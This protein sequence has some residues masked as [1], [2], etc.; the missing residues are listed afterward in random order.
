MSAVASL[1]GSRMDRD[2]TPQMSRL[3]TNTLCSTLKSRHESLPRRKRT[4]WMEK[5]V[6]RCSLLVMV[7]SL[8]HHYCQYGSSER[9]RRWPNVWSICANLH[10]IIHVASPRKN[11]FT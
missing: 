4:S 11:P 10:N 2:P 5:L 6:A 9:G 7:K 8:P 3:W 1:L